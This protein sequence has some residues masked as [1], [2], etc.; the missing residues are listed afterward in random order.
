MGWFFNP[1]TGKF[2]YFRTDAEIQAA[3]VEDAAYGAGWNGDTSHAPSQNAVY[4]KMETV[5]TQIDDNKILAFL[6]VK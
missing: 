3:A 4:D 5:Q 6:G 2:D 1:F